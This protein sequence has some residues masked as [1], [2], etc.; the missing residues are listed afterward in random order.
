MLYAANREPYLLF[1]N[2]VPYMKCTNE[3]LDSDDEQGNLY[4]FMC[5]C[6]KLENALYNK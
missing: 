6:I 4:K 5:T 3:N 1:V 2:Y